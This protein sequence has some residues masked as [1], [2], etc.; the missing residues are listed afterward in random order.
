MQYLEGT[1]LISMKTA[2]VLG[3]TGLTGGLLLNRLQKDER[4]SKIKLFSRSSIG[5]SNPKIEEHLINLY[6]L[7][8]YE[9]QF[10]GDVVFC[11]IGTTKAKTPDEQTYRKIDYGIPVAAARLAKRTGIT[12]FL[13]I[14]ALGADV[15]SRIFYNKT[16]GEMERDVL[17]EDVSETYIFR[18]SLISGER[19]E[20]RFFESLGKSLMKVGDHLLV[21]PLKKYRSIDA[22]TITKAM[23]VVAAEGYSKVRI[24]SAEI[25][26][27]ARREH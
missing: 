21:G 17:K 14:S 5:Y 16:K 22:D 27:I 18:P 11:C 4:Y 7:E 26:E 25:K 9:E 24:E 2:I 20:K 8:K 13:V 3:A 6:E 12:K 10:S 1:N 15:E 19:K 23:V